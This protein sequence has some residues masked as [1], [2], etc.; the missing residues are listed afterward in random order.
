[1]QPEK[2]RRHFGFLD[3][4]RPIFTSKGVRQAAELKSYQAWLKMQNN[5]DFKLWSDA[6]LLEAENAIS[7]KQILNISKA[8]SQ[9]IMT[10]AN[11][12]KQ[13]KSLGD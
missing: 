8:L 12:G 11:A 3:E 13:S 6:V 2:K 1:M 9:T 7:D 5:I 4:Q 10:A